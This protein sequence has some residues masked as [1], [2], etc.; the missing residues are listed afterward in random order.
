M[1]KFAFVI[2]EIIVTAGYTRNICVCGAEKRT[3][4][5]PAAGH[6]FNVEEIVAATC[7]EKGYTR[8]TCSVCGAV[9]K[10]IYMEA[11]GHDWVEDEG[12]T[13]RTC[14][15]C[16]KTESIGSLPP[17]P[18]DPPVQH[19]TVEEPEETVQP[20]EETA[21][22][23]DER[24]VAS[25][26]T[27]TY[28]YL[29][30]SGKL[31][32]EKVTTDG[33]TETHNFFYD[34][35]G[36]PYAMQVDGTTYYYITNLQS[37]VVEMVD[38]G[39][40]T[41]A[42]YTYSPYGKVLTS[43]GTLADK[44]PL[45][46]RGYYYDTESG[47]YYLQSRYYDPGT[48]RFINADEY[49]STGHGVL[50]FNMFAYCNNN[51]INKTDSSGTRPVDAYEKEFRLA[52][53]IDRTHSKKTHW[54][55]GN[56][57]IIAV[58]VSSTFTQ[59]SPDSQDGPAMFYSYSDFEIDAR[60]GAKEASFGVGAH[61]GDW[62]GGEFGLS[63][64]LDSAKIFETFQLTPVFHFGI[65][66]GKEGVGINLGVDTEEASNDLDVSIGWPTVGAILFGLGISN[67]LIGGF[68]QFGG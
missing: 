2:F 41:V 27:V 6:Q 49:G 38:A 28:S 60:L 61:L 17:Q 56:P 44:N 5:T 67:P 13:S 33:K 19:D 57:Y 32:Q 12:G 11:P 4:E 52:N 25:E 43:E 29:Y 23:S 22:D 15:R 59:L 48:G 47:L 10:T 68:P 62:L 21:S 20:A 65:S 34:N 7:T 39:G 58:E 55:K 66:I 14:T 37:D 51:P 24:I 3:N 64:S 36:T 54:K 45:R 42:S 50:G 63:V 1:S 53:H 18:T 35:S 9:E 30:A 8:G 26:T 40:N 31:L 16:R 46:Y